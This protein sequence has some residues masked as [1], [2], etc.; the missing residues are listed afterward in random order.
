MGGTVD[1]EICVIGGGLAGLATAL[2]LAERGRSVAL[3]EAHRIDWGA[4]GRN[5]GFLSPGYPKSAPELIQMVGTDH[6]RELYALSLMGHGLVL[7]RIERYGIDC[8]PVEQGQVRCSM[9]GH[10]ED[11]AGYCRL[12]NETFG[13]E[14]EYWPSQRVREALATERYDEA[15]FNPH[16][17]RLHPLNLA[18]GTARALE[19]L[20]GRLHRAIR[21]PY[22]VS[23]I[24]HPTNYYRPLADGRLMWGGRVLA[25]QPSPRQLARQ[26]G[27]DMADFYPSLAGARDGIEYRWPTDF[28]PVKL[29]L[30]LAT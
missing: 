24:Q 4:S 18:R 13:L 14:L 25:W 30:D 9:A 29:S 12:M 21:V 5:G 8:G 19:S 15:F 1:A 2:D 17:F 27:C 6:A 26:L 7:D 28:G 3:I 11:L 22:A 20:G 10:R 23:D 16:T